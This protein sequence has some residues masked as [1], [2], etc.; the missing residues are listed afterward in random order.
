MLLTTYYPNVLVCSCSSL[1]GKESE[2]LL[3]K[4]ILLLLGVLPAY[5]YCFP[6]TYEIFWKNE[7]LYYSYVE[8]NLLST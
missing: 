6:S 5:L 7:L 2:Y 8:E 1:L 3:N 4:I